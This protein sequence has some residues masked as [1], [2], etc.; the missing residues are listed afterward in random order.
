MNVLRPLRA[1]LGGAKAA[2][3]AEPARKI[4]NSPGP[5]REEL[6]YLSGKQ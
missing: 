5:K 1:N 3:L 4:V 6:T 2:N